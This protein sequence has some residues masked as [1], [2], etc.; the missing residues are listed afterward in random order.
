[1]KEVFLIVRPYYG[2]NIHTDAQGE[3]GTVLHSN[4]VFP[5]LP[6]INSVT[7]LDRSE[8]HGVIFIDA[9]TGGGLLPDELLEKISSLKYDKLI[10]KTTAATIRSDIELARQIKLKVPGS[11]IMAAGQ[12]ASDLKTWLESNTDID[13]AVKEPL[14]KFIYR[15][16]HGREG[17]VNDMPSLD[18]SLVDHKSYR[19]DLGR[20]R[21]TIQTSRGCPM[22]CAFCPYIKYYSKYE[23][24]DIDKIM[25]DI[26]SLV[27]LGA[28]VI[29]FRDQFFT[30]EK[31][32]IKELCRRII[33]E[34]IKISWICETR[35]S[36]LDAE[37]I[38]LMKQAGLFLVCFGIESGNSTILDEY[39][40]YK[41]SPE[42]SKEIVDLL[43]DKGILTM[44]FYIIGFPEDTWETVWETYRAARELGSDIVSFN[45]YVDYDLAASLKDGPGVFCPFMNS[46]ASDK[47]GNLTREEISFVSGLFSEMY[48]AEHD[49]LE[50]AYTYNYKISAGYKKTAAL[51]AECG[52]D[53]Q[54][55]SIRIRQMRS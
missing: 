51:I 55:M 54:K 28:D 36:S 47:A 40:S 29:Q 38:D 25:E 42:M 46:T 1:M 16:I 44:A 52:N 26:R 53:L 11:Y 27:A 35:L 6:L 41:G 15:Y 39:N 18:Y 31:E 24:R 12:A 34:G 13:E 10:I 45:E 5:D 22:K 7:M 50:K 37:L 32:K 49:C 8:E 20:V 14:D 17:T 30:F 43:K 3:Y 23:S 9:Y 19:D 2:I 33:E 48:T 21:L 4:D